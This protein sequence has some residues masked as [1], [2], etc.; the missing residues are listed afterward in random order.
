MQSYFIT[1]TDTEIGK[2]LAACAVMHALHRQGKSVAGMKPVAA[3]IST[4]GCNDDIRQLRAAASIT[5]QDEEICPYLFEAPIAPHLAAL[6]AGIRIEPERIINAYQALK[7]R[8]D[9][10]VIEGAGGVL[11]PFE[12]LEPNNKKAAWNTADLIKLLGCPVILV[13]GMKLGCINHALLAQE[14]LSLRS[15]PVRG[16]IAN[17]IDP[18]M[19]LVTENLA[20]LEQY[21]SFQYGV[22]CLG[23]IPYLA[24]GE[25][26][27][28]ASQFLNL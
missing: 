1:G 9:C 23:H 11:V 27:F 4:D 18:N 22:P 24:N 19:A 16:W 8:A 12:N 17:Q 5:L 14:A 7:G 3:G 26:A 13:V 20:T 6:K 10:V 21:F 15:I 28:S 2:T 25:D